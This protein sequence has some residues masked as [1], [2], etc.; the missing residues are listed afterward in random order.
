M[1]GARRSGI[2]CWLDEK[3]VLPGDDIRAE[4]DRGIRLWGK[5]LLCCSQHS[6]TSRWVNNE[7][8]IALRKE[9]QIMKDR[10]KKVLALIPLEVDGYVFS[11]ECANSKKTQI[12]SRVAAGFK[13]WENDNAKFEAE[14]EKVVKAL[15]S[16][17]GARE[18]PPEPKL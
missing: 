15:R 17:E 5:V 16:D 2:R 3:Q 12:L 10:S 6:L 18:K 14:F 8:E 4:I 13:G 11:N 1:G 7:I 9:R